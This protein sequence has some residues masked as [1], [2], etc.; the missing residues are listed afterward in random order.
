MDIFARL[1]GFFYLYEHLLCA[2]DISSGMTAIGL[3]SRNDLS[4]LQL[5]DLMKYTQSQ[6]LLS[7]TITVPRLKTI[8]NTMTK[9]IEHFCN[10]FSHY[11]PYQRCLKLIVKNTFHT[12]LYLFVF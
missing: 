12:V 5:P 6:L 8:R 9:Y 1:Q 7:V 4:T 3:V 2:G 10:A 11:S